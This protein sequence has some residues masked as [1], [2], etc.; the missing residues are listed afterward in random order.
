MIVVAPEEAGCCVSSAQSGLC[1]AG[2]FCTH[3]CKKQDRKI[4]LSTGEFET[5][6]LSVNSTSCPAG[7]EDSH[8]AQFCSVVV[9]AFEL[10]ETIKPK[11]LERDGSWMTWKGVAGAGETSLCSHL[12]GPWP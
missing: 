5:L 7:P 3:K 2:S 8:L 4:A 6:Y 1:S 10:A 12:C 9:L 11:I